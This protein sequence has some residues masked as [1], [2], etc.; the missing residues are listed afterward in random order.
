M[1]R[2]SRR[3]P[4]HSPLIGLLVAVIAVLSGLTAVA[5]VGTSGTPT[6]TASVL[7]EHPASTP[8]GNLSV[9]I[10]QPTVP[11][12]PG[13]YLV[14]QLRL[15]L[16]STGSPIPPTLTIWVPQTIA[17]FYLYNQTVQV[18]GP[19]PEINFTGGGP[20]TLP[21]I[22][23]TLL[24]KGGGTFNSTT[25]AL[26]TSQLLAFMS[27][28]PDGAVLLSVSWRWAIGFPDGSS[29]FGPWSAS[30]TVEPTL[31]A[32]LAS[33]GPTT[34]P[35]NG[36]FQICMAPSN[37]TREFSLHLETIAPVDD[38]VH[39]E[40]NVSANGTTPVCWSAQVASWVTPQPLLAHIWA[41][42]E[43]TFLLYLVKI[44][45]VAPA[46]PLAVLGPLATWNG[47][48]TVAALGL[49]AGLVVWVGSRW[50]RG[51]RGRAV[52]SGDTTSPNGPQ[53]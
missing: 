39:A 38:F 36:W 52:P 1:P 51:R 5:G 10:P 16:V 30:T 42:D 49:G 8:N 21:P 44:R 14:S 22:N 34:I 33:Y 50:T 15:T 41:Y 26:L 48:V 37:V 13:S 32:R 20:S 3:E 25:P 29:L 6:M 46:V 7:A 47:A 45:V 43:K 27:N 28:V 35:T 40:E 19:T 4:R 31:Y 11:V 17:L 12:Q 23:G 53:G 2:R 9:A 18:V 24:V